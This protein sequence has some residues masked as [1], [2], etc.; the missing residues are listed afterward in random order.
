MILFIFINYDKKFHKNLIYFTKI[1]I[2]SKYFIDLLHEILYEILN[3]K[4]HSILH[5]T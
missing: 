2:L 3:I 5:K 4:L 1:N